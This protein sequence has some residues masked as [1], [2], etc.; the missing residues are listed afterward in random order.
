LFS[1]DLLELTAKSTCQS[2]RAPMTVGERTYIETAPLS[3]PMASRL[4]AAAIRAWV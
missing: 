1:L 3:A 4:N 2:G